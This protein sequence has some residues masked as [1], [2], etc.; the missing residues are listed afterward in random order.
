MLL[1]KTIEKFP[2]LYNSS[3]NEYLKKDITDKA[4]A[5]VANQTQLSGKIIAS[6]NIG[7]Y[8][9]NINA[10]NYSRKLQRRAIQKK[11]LFT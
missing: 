4:W 2:C 6:N 7:T 9:L 8:V 5:E 3:L 11:T 10:L 1:V